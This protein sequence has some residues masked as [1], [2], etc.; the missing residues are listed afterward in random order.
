MPPFNEQHDTRD[1][2][3]LSSQGFAPDWLADEEIDDWLE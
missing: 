3:P 1:P 2:R